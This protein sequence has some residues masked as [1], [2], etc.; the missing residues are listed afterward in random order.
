[1]VGI[2]IKE[3]KGDIPNIY[4]EDETVRYLNR[5]IELFF[6]TPRKLLDEM[7]EMGF[8]KFHMYMTEVCNDLMG[9][10][11]LEIAE[12]DFK[13]IFDNK[14]GSFQFSLTEGSLLNLIISLNTKAKGV[15]TIF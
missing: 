2:F 8:D 15:K 10:Y 6:N 11:Q 4:N 3:R 12:K 7:V 5:H 1:M 9:A 14:Y 13:Y